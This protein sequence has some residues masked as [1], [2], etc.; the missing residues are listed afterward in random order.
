LEH[1]STVELVSL[2]KNNHRASDVNREAMG[3]LY[4]RHHA[5]IFH[6]LMFRLNDLQQAED[7]TGEVFVR[8]LK[9]LPG[10]QERKIP[11]E[12]W[13]YRIARNLLIDEYRKN[14]IRQYVSLNEL[15]EV[16]AADESVTERSDSA[17][18]F[19]IV[20]QAM[21]Q[22]EPS[23]REVIELRFLVGLPAKDTALVLDKT[24]HAVKALQHRGLQN[25]RA[26]IQE[27]IGKINELS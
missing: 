24:V 16:A 25:L 5:K 6:Y 1:L 3:I 12:A 14:R 11:F 20:R 22:I 19:E 2:V 13:L 21:E 18:S 15:R 10:Y 4:D 9:A 26:K 23:Q 8:M 7:L 17:W 27:I